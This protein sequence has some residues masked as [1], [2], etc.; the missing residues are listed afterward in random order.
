MFGIKIKTHTSTPTQAGEI[1]LQPVSQSTSWIGQ[2]FGF[3]WNRPVAV[4]VGDGQHEYQVP[5][6]DFTRTTL[7]LLWGLTAAFSL[8]IL[9]FRPA[10]RSKK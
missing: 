8:V 10:K 3:V 6:R 4:R 7:V 9:F 2:T 1:T 5:I